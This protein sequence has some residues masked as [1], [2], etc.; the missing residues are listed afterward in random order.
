V[1]HKHIKGA[2]SSL[3]F[4]FPELLRREEVPTWTEQDFER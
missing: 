1:N 3:A 4:F 2:R